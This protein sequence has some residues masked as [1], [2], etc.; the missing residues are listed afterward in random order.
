MQRHDK[1]R[2]PGHC[3]MVG[4]GWSKGTDDLGLGH[5]HELHRAIPGK[6]Q[7]LGSKGMATGTSLSPPFGIREAAGHP[8]QQQR[9]RICSGSR[10][11]CVFTS[12]VSPAAT[13]PFPGAVSDAGWRSPLLPR[14]LFW[15]TSIPVQELALHVAGRSAALGTRML[16]SPS[17]ETPLHPMALPGPGSETGLSPAWLLPPCR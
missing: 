16:S 8:G 5:V 13:G 11:T 9:G 4:S 10:E 6:G 15:L 17:S 7:H 1:H 12:P 3:Q 2:R 14:L